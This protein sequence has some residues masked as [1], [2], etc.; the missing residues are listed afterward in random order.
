MRELGREYGRIGSSTGGIPVGMIA[1]IFAWFFINEYVTPRIE[2]LIEG[3]ATP[4]RTVRGE[5][6]NRSR[7][8]DVID[9]QIGA[10]I[11]LHR[12]S[13]HRYICGT[14]VYRTRR[15]GTRT[16][17]NDRHPGRSTP[18]MERLPSPDT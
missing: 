8:R 14:C 12:V 9:L 1:S 11:R 2:F 16:A 5:G 3:R 7:Y 17:T 18:S 4:R 13:E 15:F 10:T 6:P